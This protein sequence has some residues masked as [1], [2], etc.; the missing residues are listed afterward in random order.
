MRFCTLLFGL[1]ALTP[2]WGSSLLVED[3]QGNRWPRRW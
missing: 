1:L 3:S 2:A